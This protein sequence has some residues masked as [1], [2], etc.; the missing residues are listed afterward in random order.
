MQLPDG[1]YQV[2]LE[3]SDDP[4]NPA[5]RALS[6][7]LDSETFTID[8]TPP[9]VQVTARR[10][11]EKKGSGFTV[12]ANATDGMGPIARA[13]YSVDARRFVPVAPEDGVSDSTSESYRIRIDSPGPGEHIVIVKVTDL[14]GNIGA[15]KAIFTAD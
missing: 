10:S 14:L 1:L 9:S 12:E 8:N 6:T 11:D 2:R 4:S 5:D 15:G 7:A 3:A 13:E